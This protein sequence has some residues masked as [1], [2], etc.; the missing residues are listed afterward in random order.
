MILW[1]TNGNYAKKSLKILST[2]KVSWVRRCSRNVV[3]TF[4]KP[5]CDN[6]L[7]PDARSGE[8]CNTLLYEGLAK[9][10]NTF[11][12]KY[13]GKMLYRHGYI[14]KKYAKIRNLSNQNP[15]PALKTQT[16]IN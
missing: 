7:Q 3:L 6:V 12:L 2:V 9:R 10:F 13:T 1:R 15:N 4:A 14:S 11:V 8:R 16:G 5:Q